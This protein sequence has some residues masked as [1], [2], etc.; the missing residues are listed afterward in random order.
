VPVTKVY[1][2]YDENGNCQIEGICDDCLRKVHGEVPYV[3]APRLGDRAY[4]DACWQVR[5]NGGCD[6]RATVV[7]GPFLPTRSKEEVWESWTIP[8]SAA[9]RR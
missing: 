3:G 6:D 1:R 4:C 8:G 7:L 5:W 9:Y 2:S